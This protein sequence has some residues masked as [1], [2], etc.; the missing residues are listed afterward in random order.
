[1]SK[2]QKKFDEDKPKLE[3]LL[4]NLKNSGKLSKYT[5][6]ELKLIE[7]HLTEDKVKRLKELRRRLLDLGFVASLYRR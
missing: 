6:E 4:G 5:D 7:A 1:M 3:M 2:A